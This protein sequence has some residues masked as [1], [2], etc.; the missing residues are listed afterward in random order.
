M[1]CKIKK[2]FSKGFDE[3]D[4]I[5]ELNS[6]VKELEAEIKQLKFQLEENELEYKD[7][8][9]QCENKIET[10]TEN[11]FKLESTNLEIAFKL[12]QISSICCNQKD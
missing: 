3:N 1:L 6:R 4:Y 7:N 12:N 2:L 10:L 5:A 11:N 8:L 9:L